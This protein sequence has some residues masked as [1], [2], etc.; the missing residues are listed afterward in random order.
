M[1]FRSTL[2]TKTV[3]GDLFICQLYV[4]E[5]IF[6]STNKLFN[7]E[8]YKLMTDRFEISMMGE[9]EYFLGFEIK[10]YQEGSFIKQEKYTEDMITRFKMH[11]AK[12][13]KT[14]MSTT[15]DLKPNLDGKE[16]DQKVYRF[17]IGSLI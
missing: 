6:G 11:E 12:P 7:E 15:L 4:D 16:V 3:G 10:Q 2:F 17:V 13:M 5:I 9:L 1:L 14:P 8:F